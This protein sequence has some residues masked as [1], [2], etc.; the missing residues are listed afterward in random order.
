MNSPLRIVY[1][2]DD[3][4]DVRLVQDAFEDD[5][6]CLQLTAVDNRADFLAA[7][8]QSPD[9]ILADY[10]LPT[11]DG[12]EALALCREKCP[13]RPFIFVTGAVGEERAIDTLKSG[14]TDYV[15][16][17]RLSRLTM[18]VRRA[19]AEAED[20]AARK[21]AVEQ[22]NAAKAAAEIASEAKSRFLANVS[23]ELRTP[24]NAILGMVDFALP[25]V[26]DV[27]A[28]DCLQ[29]AK[30]SA[31]LLLTLL[32]DLLDSAKI[33]SG[34]L[35]LESAP[36][37][38]RQML[39]QVS[40]AFAMRAGE[41]GLSFRCHVPDEVP[42]LLLGDRLRLQ[43]VLFNLAGNAVKFTEVGGVEIGVRCLSQDRSASL[44]FEVRDTGIGIPPE[45]LSQLFQPFQ[46]ADASMARRYGGSGL[47]L[48]ICKSLVHLMEGDIRVESAA[49]SGT[50]FFVTVRLPMAEGLAGEGQAPDVASTA[51]CASLHI[52]LVEDNAAN[53]KL[54]T[55][56]LRSRG[57]R[58]DIAVNGKEAVQVTEQIRYDAILMDV[59]MPIMNGLD[60]TAAIRKRDS[61]RG[62]GRVPIIAMTAH[63]TPSD[64]LRCKTAGMDG[65]LCKPVKS[66]EL[67]TAVEQ[68]A[69]TGKAAAAAEATIAAASPAAPSQLA[70][71]DASPIDFRL[72]MSRLDGNFK[73]FRQMA[74]FF[75]N[76]VPKVMPEIRSAV[77]RTDLD[78][79]ADKAH[80]LKGSVL[81][82]GATA[83]T[84]VLD[85]LES[86]SRAGDG[87]VATA[88]VE[89][90]EVEVERLT[91]ALLRFTPEPDDEPATA[92][93]ASNSR[94]E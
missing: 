15:L 14:A 27:V 85:R 49:Q 65:Y 58:V 35:D 89:A 1:L 94:G 28:R 70:N 92:R 40:R 42:D 63:A 17:T 26:S 44:E 24:M 6:M 33:E 80:W 31:D 67:V 88:A 82:L 36:F 55:Y 77:A 30:E 51:R 19:V 37:S 46:Q 84:A 57:H 59:Q 2:E 22:L 18:A 61:A 43:Q 10:A 90:L 53:Q 72:A 48:S 60:A 4:A 78:A 13:E 81:Y 68:T 47:G 66:D 83:V 79:L 56:V 16:K 50:T 34:K 8:E 76:D 41:K 45:S 9:L 3:P 69:A 23:H 29:T 71:G 86:H 75:F 32:N 54:A 21:K 91:A 93:L 7:L 11:F 39:E 20:V 25:R 73:L 64:R 38:L 12:M 62:R 5:G 87:A 52:L 74:E